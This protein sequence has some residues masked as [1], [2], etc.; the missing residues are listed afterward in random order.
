VVERPQAPPDV[1]AEPSRWGQ[2]L[3]ALH[4]GRQRVSSRVQCS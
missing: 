3:A 2:A 1:L 4:R